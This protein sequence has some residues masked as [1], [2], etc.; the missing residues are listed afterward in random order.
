MI[1]KF[2]HIAIAVS[3]LES[4]TAAFEKIFG[5]KADMT[6]EVKDQKVKVAMFDVGGVLF[7]I[8]QPTEMGTPVAQFVDNRGNAL[9]HVSF[10]VD[11]IEKTIEEFTEKNFRMIDAKPRMGAE[12]KPI[13]FM[14]PKS[15]EGILVEFVED[16]EETK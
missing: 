16:K 12:G 14:H 9:H 10:S 6:V 4:S 7:E 2:N 3:D 11:D 1:K 13:A 8:I 5:K 15:S